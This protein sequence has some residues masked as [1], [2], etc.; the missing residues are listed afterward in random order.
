[1]GDVLSLQN[2]LAIPYKDIPFFKTTRV[3][4]HKG[5]LLLGETGDTHV[6]VLQGRIHYYEG[7]SMDEIT[8]PV[9]VLATL[10]VKNLILTNAAGGIA[11]DFFPGDLVTITDHINLMGDHPLRGFNHDQLGPRFP[12]MSKAYNP[13]LIQSLS[14]C[15]EKSNITLKKGVYAALSGPSY[16]T[17]AEIKMLHT[18]GAHMVGMSTVPESIAA[19]HAGLKVCGITCITNKA[20][21]LSSKTLDHDDVKK[22]ASEASSNLSRL[23]REFILHLASGFTLKKS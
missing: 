10:G 14:M 16:E 23:L 6:A 9:R 3:E 8:L 21:G 11:E 1:M 17:P 7:Y 5:T 22:Q 18:L 13:G 15:A 19:N 20:A 12:D 4:G 2:S